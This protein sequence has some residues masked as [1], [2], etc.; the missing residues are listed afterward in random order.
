MTNNKASFFVNW[1]ND[2]MC[3][4]L[5]R[6]IPA[7]GDFP[8]AGDSVVIDYIDDVVGRSP[9]LKRIF[10]D[11]LVQ[12]QRGSQSDYQA[13]F[14]AIRDEDKDVL[15]RKIEFENPGFFQQLIKY[16]YIAYY[17]DRNII[18]LLGLEVRPPQPE[19][20]HLDQMSD[21]SILEKVKKVKNRGPI[22]RI[23]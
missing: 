21:S 19:G 13:D 10:S 15:L 22:Y 2:L 1:Q 6:I 20:Y 3:A 7:S 16:T 23:V 18:R 5:N 9:E 11:G 17:S 4:V 8:G 12:I 14:I